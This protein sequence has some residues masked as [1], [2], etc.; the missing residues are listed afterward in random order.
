[1]MSHKWLTLS[2][3]RKNILSEIPDWIRQDADSWSQDLIADS[4]L[5]S[6]IQYMIENGLISTESSASLEQKI[7]AWM[8]NNVKW[9]LDDQISD[10]DFI[11]SIQYL[12]ENQVIQV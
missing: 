5:L 4:K 11:E 12:I 7:P 6:G 1:M 3:D 2:A 10:N 9:W 8:K